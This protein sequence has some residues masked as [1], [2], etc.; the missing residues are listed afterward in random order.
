MEG[1]LKKKRAEL[2][3]TEQSYK[4]EQ[5]TLDTLKKDIDKLRVGLLPSVDREITIND[6][7]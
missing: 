4:K 7:L 1:E 6:A 5:A 2:K 3:D